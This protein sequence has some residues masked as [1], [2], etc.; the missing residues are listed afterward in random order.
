MCGKDAT[1]DFQG[2]H[3]GQ[4]EPEKWLETLKI[5]KLSQ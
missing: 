4:G 2:E 1:E 3:Q 5:G